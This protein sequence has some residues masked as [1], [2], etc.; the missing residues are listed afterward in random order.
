MKSEL[1]FLIGDA[2]LGVFDLRI[3]VAVDDDE[4]VPAVVV[5]VD[6]GVAPAD[7]GSAGLGDAGDDTR[8]R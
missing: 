6:K 5:E 1:W 8:R 4:V 7:V 3:D 2:G